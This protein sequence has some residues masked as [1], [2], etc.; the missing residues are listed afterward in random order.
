MHPPSLKFSDRVGD[1]EDHTLQCIFLLGSVGIEVGLDNG[2][3][4]GIMTL[5]EAFARSSCL[6]DCSIALF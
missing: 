3:K 5:A 4:L 6:E 2:T 1:L